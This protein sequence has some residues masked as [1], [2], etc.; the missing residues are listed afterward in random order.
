VALA[1]SGRGYFL[2][3]P[4]RHRNYGH[5][6]LVAFL[7]EL[8]VAAAKAKLDTIA[9]GDLGQVRGG[10]AAS[11]HASHQTG[12]DVDIAYLTHPVGT[13]AVSLVEDKK[14]T[15]GF[16][17]R[18]VRLL[19]I[20]A[21]DP[22]VE[23]IFV[24]PALKKVLC[25]RTKDKVWLHKIRPWYAHA[26]HFHV[27]LYCPPDSPLCESQ[28]ALADGDG[29]AE[30]DWWLSEKAQADR[31]KSHKDYGSRVGAV[32]VLPPACDAVSAG[33]VVPPDPPASATPDGGA[34]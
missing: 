20:V 11:G 27:R 28:Q 14:A 24:N 4:E 30:L 3:H 33:V 18:V 26:D 10:P 31:D 17:A 34:P 9:V 32:P 12:L 7:R 23:R 29:C 2:S 13:P 21:A 5:P 6:S 1:V 25:E 19:Q 8:A 16:S 22:R 15:A